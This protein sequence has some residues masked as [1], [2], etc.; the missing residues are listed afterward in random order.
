MV[1]PRRRTQ[2][3]RRATTRAA[4]LD[5]AEYLLID[6]GLGAVTIAAVAERAQVSSG[7]VLH[8]FATKNDLIVNLASHLSDASKDIAVVSADPNAPL[9][10]RIDAMADAIVAVVFDPAS[11]AQFELHTAS[12]TAPEFAKHLHELNARN[13][14]AYVSDLAAALLDAN[15]PVERVQAALEFSI[16]AAIGLSLLTISGGDEPAEERLAASIKALLIREVEA[17]AESSP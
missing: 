3:E 2:S 12:R 4:I 5:A 13:A 9:A 11:R 16:C 6:K 17:A 15:V 1:P 7:A 10:E 14:E 8:H